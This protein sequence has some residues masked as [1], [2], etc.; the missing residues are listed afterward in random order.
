[1]DKV[2]TAI[3]TTIYKMDADEAAEL[4][5]ETDEQKITDAILAKDK[6]RVKA[7]N[8]EKTK[9][10]DKG[11]KKAQAESLTKFE[12]KLREAYEIDDTDLKGEDLISKIVEIKVSNEKTTAGKSKD[13]LT[14]E[15][16]K[17]HPLYLQLEQEKTKAV[18]KVEDEWT[19]KWND[20][21][22]E[23]KKGTVL[24][25]VR[26]RALEKFDELNPELPKDPKI[27]AKQKEWF[28]KELESDFE[29]ELSE[30]GKSLIPLQNGEAAK[31]SHGNA[32]TFDD[33]I[34]E[35]VSSSFVIP[36]V[37][38]KD[39]AGGNRQQQGAG[40]GANGGGGN[41]PKPKSQEE[42]AKYMMDT[43]IKLEDRQKI[44]SDFTAANGG[45]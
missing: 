4:L 13:K 17:R 5:K 3:L 15:D 31:D 23:I 6:E 9:I 30:D 12:E 32:I 36:V 27:A 18:K 38:P 35:R 45:E 34:K 42:L 7:F 43:T 39:G 41:L 14:D 25:T 10:H 33:L 19:A 21:E 8:D 20:K 40:A 37:K 44:Y 29:Y 28:L 22:K 16:I 24:S 11:Y 2:L 26:Q 1:M